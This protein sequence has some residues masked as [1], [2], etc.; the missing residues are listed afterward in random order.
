MG[1]RFKG[2][3][4]GK[5]KRKKEAVLVGLP[6]AVD[7]SS[8][9]GADPLHCGATSS[10]E[11]APPRWAVTGT[12]ATKWPLLVPPQAR[13]SKLY[14]PSGQVSRTV[15]PRTPLGVLAANTVRASGR[16]YVATGAKKSP[17]PRFPAAGGD[18][19]PVEPP[20]LRYPV[21][22]LSTPVRAPAAKPPPSAHAPPLR[23]HHRS[24]PLS[25]PSH[26][27]RCPTCPRSLVPLSQ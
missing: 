3:G 25:V 8:D 26:P 19:V 2:M 6:E 13:L 11:A 27:V 18:D 15:I 20:Q 12:P 10:P 22:S 7:N 24:A 16:D 23:S 14:S 4:F 5:K 1:K 9:A 21:S 17:K